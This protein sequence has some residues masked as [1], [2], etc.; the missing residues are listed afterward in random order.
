MTIGIVDVARRAAA[1]EG[2]VP[3]VMTSTG[4]ATSSAASAGSASTDPYA[5]RWEDLHVAALDESELAVSLVDGLKNLGLTLG[6]AG[7]PVGQCERAFAAAELAR[8]R[9]SWPRRRKS[10]QAARRA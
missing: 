7:C 6:P 10:A 1:I 4:N 2:L 8:S 9:A 3:A 5:Q